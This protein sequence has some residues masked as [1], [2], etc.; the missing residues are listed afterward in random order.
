MRNALVHTPVDTAIE[1]SVT[2]D[3]QQVRIAVCDAGPGVP[4]GRLADIFEPFV[5]MP[6]AQ[7]DG[8]GLGLAI[9]RR[10]IERM[11]GQIQAH[12]RSEGG[13]S[14]EITLPIAERDPA[15]P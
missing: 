14:V 2:R 3:G 8:H 11:G 13:L 15:T 10:V 1:V 5:R 4:P 7:C 12:N 6:G 9:A